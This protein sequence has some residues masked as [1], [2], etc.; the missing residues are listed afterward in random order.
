MENDPVTVRLQDPEGRRGDAS[1]G[2]REKF[3]LYIS[4]KK[5]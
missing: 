1:C 2:I 4:G 5:D 3:H